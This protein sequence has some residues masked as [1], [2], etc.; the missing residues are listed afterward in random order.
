VVTADPPFSSDQELSGFID[1]AFA[2][3]TAGSFSGRNP[4]SALG[5]PVPPVLD[6][7]FTVGSFEWTAFDSHGVLGFTDVTGRI[8]TAM[9][10][11]ERD[12]CGDFS[13]CFLDIS[14]DGPGLFKVQVYQPGIGDEPPVIGYRAEG[15]ELVADS[16][17]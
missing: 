17:R 14:N 11:F 2:A 13:P 16:L 8:S 15:V 5:S 4:P 7:R 10:G 3:R 6:F 1:V 9:M 12:A